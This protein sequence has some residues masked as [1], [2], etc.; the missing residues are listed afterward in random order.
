MV[1]PE[2][3]TEAAKGCVIDVFFMNSTFYFE[4]NE[5]AISSLK[6]N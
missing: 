6:I 1:I 2:S 4:E 5:C 3:K